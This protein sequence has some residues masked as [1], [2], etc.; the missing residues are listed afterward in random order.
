MGSESHSDARNEARE[1]FFALIE[2]ELAD[3]RTLSEE[4]RRFAERLAAEDPECRAF[5]AAVRGLA[6]PEPVA[7]AAI[8][9]AIREHARTSRDSRRRGIAAFALTTAAAAAIAAIALAL[10]FDEPGEQRAPARDAGP[11]SFLAAAGGTPAGAGHVFTTTGSPL[12]LR[13]DT[14]VAVGL[15]SSSSIGVASLDEEVVALRL[16]RGRV[17]IHL[18]PGGSRR[19]KVITPLCEVAVTGTVFSVAVE[20]DEV[21]VSV[22]RG[23][24]IVSSAARAEIARVTAGHRFA[25]RADD[26]APLDGGSADAI[27]ALLELRD[28]NA[29]APPAAASEETQEPPAAVAPIPADAGASPQKR[30]GDVR[31]KN[32]SAAAADTSTQPAV[33]TPDDLIRRARE[34]VKAQRWA[35]AIAA[36]RQIGRDFPLRQ[37][38]ITVRV[39]L[40]EIELDHL[41]S[42]GA[43]LTDYRHYLAAAPNGPLAENAL[44]GV[45]SALRRM[46][47]T[48][49]EA[50][51]LREFLRRF[52]QS[53]HAPAAKV[54]LE[55]LE[56]L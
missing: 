4:E 36:Y 34:H 12:L 41:G 43:A 18:V 38:A 3:E 5:S 10:V 50:S 53:L 15:D 29:A 51:S 2:A 22:V 28:A 31:A 25:F 52:P 40:A 48:A 26:T 49:D 19:V 37:E 21:H 47:R 20:P 42:P 56:N 45:C 1:R 32:G 16:A 17:A 27:L 6:L 33:E 54:R 46:G 55:E 8:D 30:G 44:F 23:S 11:A 39:P 7:P 35:D 13:S 24:V 14:D 9:R